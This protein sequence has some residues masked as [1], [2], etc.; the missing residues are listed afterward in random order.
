MAEKMDD[1]QKTREA[2]IRE[3]E[4][5]RESEKKWRQWFE[6]APISLWEQDY[7]EVKRRVDEIRDRGVGDLEAYFQCHPD[8]CR[9]LAALVRVVDVNK[10]T[11]RL[12]RARTREDLLSGITRVFSR[13]SYES[14]IANLMTVAE[15][16]TRFFTERIHV[17]LD[18]EILH[19]Q[20]HWAVAPGYEDTYGR[21]LVS[22]VDITDRQHAEEALRESEN[23]Y[24]IVLE[25][26][27]EGYHEVDLQG[28]FTF[29]NESSQKILGYSHEELMG[30]SYRYFAADETNRNKVAVAY[31][32]IFTTGEILHD[33]VWDIVRKDG[34]RRTIEVSASLIRDK[35]N[36]RIGFRGLVR[37]ITERVHAEADRERLR[38]QL[39][40]AQKMESVGRLAGGVAHDFNNM[41]SVILG[42]AEMALMQ[43]EPSDPLHRRLRQIQESAMRS[44]N[45]VRQLLAFARKQTVAPKVLDLNNTVAGMLKMLRR[46][47]GEDI[48]LVWMPGANLWP[49][50]MDPSQIDQVLANLC[51]NARDAIVDVGKVTIET[52]NVVLDEAYCAS[53]AGF[54]PGQYTVLAVGD[55]GCGMD[56]EILV[57]LF[58]PFFTTKE[59]GKGTGLG[60]ATVY[61]IV[62]QNSGFIN[63]HSEPDQGTTFRIYLPR[64]G[65]KAPQ[66]QECGS[67]Q[68]VAGGNEAVLLVE[69]A[70]MLLGIGRSMLE[71]LGYRVLSAGGPD[72]AIRLAEADTGEIHLLMTDVV[73]PAM[74]GKE[75]A[76][77]LAELRPAIKTLF[78]S[79]YTANVI[80]HH[81]VLNEGVHFI[82]KPFS[83]KDLSAK[84]REAIDR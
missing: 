49:V 67:L 21:V 75:L 12:Y 81:G 36:H 20:L 37:D 64:H 74:N 70:P 54:M 10:F 44:A 65:G 56:K 73:M 69:D 33:F 38:A 46:L 68:A 30:M 79:G 7:S 39:A 14:F 55:N 13:V 53:H 78:M 24:R 41:L 59:V 57:N 17:A 45:L 52:E 62:K 76:R 6:D 31:N 25:S 34:L 72:E 9:E 32:R 66:D 83:I 22:I 28:R 11:L 61:G 19:V 29:L 71:Q 3:I 35:D 27:E 50:K 48:D 82:Q 15:G 43:V 26:M 23:K 84:V 1:R 18:G 60:L 77:R 2:L 16:R 42:H 40:Q 47:I 58:D 4:T 51:V 80:A 5:L 63:V 8:L